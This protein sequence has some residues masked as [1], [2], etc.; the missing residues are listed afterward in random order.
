MNERQQS[1]HTTAAGGSDPKGS[2]GGGGFAGRNLNRVEKARVTPETATIVNIDKAF[3][4]AESGRRASWNGNRCRKVR[5]NCRFLS[6]Q[7]TPFWERE[8]ATCADSTNRPR[9]GFTLS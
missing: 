3:R 4:R 5:P 6:C 1:W 7:L 9:P 8:T 2:C